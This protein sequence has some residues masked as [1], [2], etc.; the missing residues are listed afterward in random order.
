[1]KPFRD[2]SLNKTEISLWVHPK[3]RRTPLHLSPPHIPSPC[4]SFNVLP[5]FLFSP[6][7]LFNLPHLRSSLTL[8]IPLSL[9]HWLGILLSG[10]LSLPP[11]L[12]LTLPLSS[13]FP[14]SLPFSR[15]LALVRTRARSLSSSL[16]LFS[17]TSP[18]LLFPSS[19][20]SQSHSHY[21]FFWQPG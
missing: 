13:P 10:C 21:L 18:S 5:S 16:P 2:L 1:M 14:S 7:P 4:L 20:F 6:S 17:T 19:C 3:S 9:S 8:C 15:S 12:F 11:S